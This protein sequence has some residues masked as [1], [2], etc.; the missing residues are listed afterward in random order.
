MHLVLHDYAGHP[1]QVELSRALCRRGHEVTHIYFSGD[2]GPKG[3]FSVMPNE[4][5]KLRFLG[6][7]ARREY[8]KSALVSRRFG[9]IEYGRAVAAHIGAL[10]P[11]IVLSGNTPTEAQES[12]LASSHRAGAAFVYWLQDFYSIAASRLLKK[13]LGALGALIGAY[14]RRLE[15]RQLRRS[16]GVILITEDF[17]TLAGRWAGGTDKIHAIENWGPLSEISRPGKQN[18]WA[19]EN[20][21][22]DR[23]VILYAGTLALKHD[24]GLLLCLAR[25]WRDDPAVR[26]VVIGHGVGVD[27]LHEARQDECLSNLILLPL[28][29]MEELS[30]ALA[31]ADVLVAVIEQ[32]AGAFSVPSKVQTYLCAERPVLLSAHEENLASRIVVRANAGL[33]TPPGDYQAFMQACERLLA[34]RPLRETLARNGRA[35]AEGA[36]NI[37]CVAARFDAAFQAALQRSRGRAGRL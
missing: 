25:R 11:D 23:F 29:P 18:A 17:R 31:A 9:D 10:K 12:I 27:R 19:R 3:T 22:N 30:Q 35:Y 2:R 4:S 6:I 24:P 34:D 28:L 7:P 1:F 5:G 8:D 33:V 36:F 21:L 32:D 15:R 16:D 14:Y 20:A 13:K 26:V 37:E